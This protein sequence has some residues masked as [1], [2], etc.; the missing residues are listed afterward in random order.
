MEMCGYAAP[1]PLLGSV[2]RNVPSIPRQTPPAEEGPHAV[3]SVD[4]TFAMLWQ[5]GRE[6][7][8]I[9]KAALAIN[10]AQTVPRAELPYTATRKCDPL[11][12]AQ[13]VPVGDATVVND[14]T[15]DDPRMSQIGVPLIVVK[16]LF[17]GDRVSAS[18][19]SVIPFIVDGFCDQPENSD[20]SNGGCNILGICSSRSGCK[21]KAES[22]GSCYCET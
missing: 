18:F 4:E 5:R 22:C 12:I 15:F 20:A 3:S 1:V 6:R 9:F 21:S 8:P 14:L 2:Q 16:G 11:D 19:F 13:P 17:L 10:R 7:E